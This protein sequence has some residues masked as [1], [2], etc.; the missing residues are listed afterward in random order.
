MDDVPVRSRPSARLSA[1]ERDSETWKVVRKVIDDRVAA[2]RGK[3]SLLVLVHL[4]ATGDFREG[5]SDSWRRFAKREAEQRGLPHLDRVAELRRMPEQSIEPLF[6][7]PGVIQYRAAAGP[8]TPK[9][10]EWVAR[11]V[12][13]PLV[14]QPAIEERLQALGGLREESRS[15]ASPQFERRRSDAP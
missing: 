15:E 9:G 11:E 3:R 13:D 5:I 12:Y 10:N 1:T 6:I 2:N 7:A 8:L 14:A 4:P